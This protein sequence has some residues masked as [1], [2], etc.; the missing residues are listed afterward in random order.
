MGNL[1]VKIKCLD[2]RVKNI[3]QVGS[4]NPT[5]TILHCCILRS[6]FVQSGRQLAIKADQPI[7]MQSKI[8]AYHRFVGLDKSFHC[9]LRTAFQLRVYMGH[10]LCCWCISVVM[11][12]RALLCS[13][14]Y[15]TYVH[16]IVQGGFLKLNL[17]GLLCVCACVLWMGVNVCA[18]WCAPFG[19]LCTKWIAH[20]TMCLCVVHMHVFYVWKFVCTGMHSKNVHGTMYRCA[21]AHM[22]SLSCC[23][24]I[25]PTTAAVWIV[26]GT[27]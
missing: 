15:W 25:N 27:N 23:R 21:G 16:G 18:N 24:P 1:G 12:L 13:C 6:A 22:E 14:A 11:V 3:S 10:G 8:G 2:L 9:R 17:C 20:V 26:N 19:A 4:S 5:E 7:L